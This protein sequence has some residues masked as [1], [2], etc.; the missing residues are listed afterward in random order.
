MGSSRFYKLT[1][2]MQAP[3]KQVVLT[4]TKNKIRLN[5]M[6]TDGILNPCYFTEATQTHTLTI[7]GVRDV[8]VEIT[9]GLR[10]DLHGLYSIHD[11]A[12]ILIAQH[13]ISYLLLCS[14]CVRRQ[15]R[16]CPTR[17]LLYNSRCKGSISAP[18]IT[19]SP[20]KERVVI[21]IRA[22]VL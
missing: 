3:A 14:C 19:P 4:N 21:D 20:V 22:T 2:D 7:A 8:P 11:E 5:A 15:R 18:M 9:G 13:A 1:P 12:D 16:V 6:I 10:I 17:S